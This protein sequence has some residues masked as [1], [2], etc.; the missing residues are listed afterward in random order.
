MV[1]AVILTGG[2]RGNPLAQRCWQSQAVYAEK[3]GAR[4]HQVDLAEGRDYLPR[5]LDAAAG[6]A[7][8]TRVLWLEWDVEIHEKSP[9]IF[10]HIEGDGL[11]LRAHPS[12]LMAALGYCN[13]GVM[14][15]SGRHFAAIRAKLPEVSG[16]DPNL[17]EPVF[18]RAIHSAGV[19]TR[20]LDIRF[21]AIPPET[22]YFAH[23]A[24][25]F[26]R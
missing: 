26:S 9:D 14:V 23:L 6:F 15:G 13:I 19:P 8:V 21:N 1:D 18:C 16:S 5:L 11:A 4:F 3:I 22:G 12:P 7:P 10:N 17:W 2:T 25:P 20:P 24:G